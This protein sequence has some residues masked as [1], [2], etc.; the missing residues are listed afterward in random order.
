MSHARSPSAKSAQA[1]VKPAPRRGP[2]R[3]AEVS[4]TSRIYGQR[5]RTNGAVPSN[6][7]GSLGSRAGMRNLRGTGLADRVAHRTPSAVSETET[8]YS[9][10]RRRN[11]TRSWSAVCSSHAS[12]T[13]TVM[14]G[15]VTAAIESM[16]NRPVSDDVS[17]DET[18]A[19]AHGSARACD[20]GEDGEPRRTSTISDAEPEPAASNTVSD[21]NNKARVGLRS[22]TV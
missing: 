5:T 7:T 14:S 21:I 15:S 17:S 16:N 22:I 12:G 10:F 2:H 9:D 1:G 13:R 4:V 19:T 11:S 6:A 3:N 8:K 18:Y 20:Q